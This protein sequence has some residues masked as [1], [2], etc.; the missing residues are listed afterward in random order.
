[1]KILELCPCP[2]TFDNISMQ[3]WYISEFTTLPCWNYQRTLLYT[4]GWEDA[5]G[6]AASGSAKQKC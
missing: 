3:F 5:K 6:K 1:M 2:L 4:V